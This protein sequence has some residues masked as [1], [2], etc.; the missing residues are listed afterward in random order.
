MSSTR[1]KSIKM[2]IWVK[3]A[4]AVSLAGATLLISGCAQG[5]DKIS[6]DFGVALKQD[7]AAQIAYPEGA[8]ATEPVPADGVRSAA[9]MTRYQEGRVI[10]PSASASEV[11]Q[12]ADSASA[13][14]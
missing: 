2:R 4:L 5:V 13:R 11:G 3:G 7:L 14:Q 6:P 8:P 10:A 9:A 1:E 12:T